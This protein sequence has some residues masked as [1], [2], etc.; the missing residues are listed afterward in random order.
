MIIFQ[1]VSISHISEKTPDFDYSDA[2]KKR[3]P[4]TEGGSDYDFDN[5]RVRP[6]FLL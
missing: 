2:V 3:L 6:L 5:R 1:R 4:S